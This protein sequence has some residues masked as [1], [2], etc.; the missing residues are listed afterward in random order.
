[1][2]VCVCVY[3]CCCALVAREPLLPDEVQTALGRYIY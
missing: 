2:C 3:V 1:M